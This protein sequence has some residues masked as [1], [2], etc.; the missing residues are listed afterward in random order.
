MHNNKYL[1]LTK[2]AS[3]GLTRRN[4]RSP[5]GK[6]VGHVTYCIS[7]R[8]S[9]WT[10]FDGMN[11]WAGNSTAPNRLPDCMHYPLAVLTS[12]SKSFNMFLDVSRARNSSV[13]SQFL[14]AA[15]HSSTD[16]AEQTT[17][18]SSTSCVTAATLSSQ[19]RFDKMSL[20]SSSRW[21][22]RG[23]D[24]HSSF[25]SSSHTH[26]TRSAYASTS[27]AHKYYCKCC[28]S[29]TLY[30]ASSSSP[31]ISVQKSIS[32]RRS[33]K[34]RFAKKEHRSR[35]RDLRFVHG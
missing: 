23:H 30:F 11:E 13:L 19:M 3:R 8:A 31:D 29:S 2:R 16:R 34:V 6:I 18:P 15:T 12:T 1:S 33:H 25:N 9:R 17:T 4:T 26:G 35:Y 28:V 24:A 27:V 14:P 32:L 22:P 5:D 7:N 21:A 10:R 20:F